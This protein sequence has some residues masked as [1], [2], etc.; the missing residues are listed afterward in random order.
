MN[1]THGTIERGYEQ[2]VNSIRSRRQS[3]TVALNAPTES[4][5]RATGQLDLLSDDQRID[6]SFFLL[7]LAFDVDHH[8]LAEFIE[9]DEWFYDLS[10]KQQAQVIEF[11][12]Q[13]H[14]GGERK[15]ILNWYETYGHKGAFRFEKA[16]PPV[17]SR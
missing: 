8:S 5:T 11:F 1:D 7:D 10:S 12:R 4:S 3:L 6:A 9:P 2:K 17:V 13:Q 16:L 14:I 15:I